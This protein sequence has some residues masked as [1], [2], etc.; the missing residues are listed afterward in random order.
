MNHHW[1]DKAYYDRFEATLGNHRSYYSGVDK[2][3]L[4]LWNPLRS[5]AENYASEHQGRNR[6]TWPADKRSEEDDLSRE[7][8]IKSNMVPACR[9]RWSW[10]CPFALSAPRHNSN[11]YVNYQVM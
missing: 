9:Y 1:K 6:E 2:S 7:A 5:Q 11:A 10:D 8:W 3:I 4:L